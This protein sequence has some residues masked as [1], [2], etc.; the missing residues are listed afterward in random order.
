MVDLIPTGVLLLAILVLTLMSAYFSSSETAMMKLNPYRLRHKVEQKHRGARKTNRLLRR[1]DRLLGVILIGNNLVNNCA[2]VVASIVFFRWFGEIGYPLAAVALTIFFLIFA[3]VAPKTIAAKRPEAIAF[4][5]SYILGPLLSLLSP[6]VKLFN[7]CANTMVKPLVGRTKED[8]EQLS[9]EELRTVVDSGTNIPLK[10]QEML[11]RILDL[12]KI[13]VNDIMVPASDIVGIDL[14]D[15]DDEI[16]DLLINSSHTRLPIYKGEVNSISAVLHIRRAGKF[17]QESEFD[18]EDLVNAADEPY[19]VPTSTTLPTQLVNFQQARNRIALVV[20]EY[21]DIKGLVTLED[22]LEEI[23]GDYTTGTSDNIINI[24]PQDDGHFIIDGETELREVNAALNWN[25]PTDGPR[26]VN[27]L[28]LESLEDIPDGNV[29]I[30]IGRY[31]FETIQITENAVRSVYAIE[32][33]EQEAEPEPE[34]IPPT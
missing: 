15:T 34:D 32:T 5:S 16:I 8:D 3:E 17:M 25:L 19:F 2:A 4:P 9:M 29:G 6:L 22:I 7:W 12:E 21:G 23:V 14:E 18:R 11:L 20:D 13:T 30:K 1:T 28:L 31:I 27:G 26:T 24:H 33:D 10:R